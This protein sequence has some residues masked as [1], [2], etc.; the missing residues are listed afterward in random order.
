MAGDVATVAYIWRPQGPGRRAGGRFPNDYCYISRAFPRPDLLLG[1]SPVPYWEPVVHRIYH[2]DNPKLAAQR[3][4]LMSG[5]ATN[6]QYESVLPY[7]QFARM[8]AKIAHAYAIAEWGL[9]SFRGILPPY[10]LGQDPNIPYVVGGL[11]SWEG[12]LIITDGILHHTKFGIAV[13]NGF[14]HLIAAIQLFGTKY[15]RYC[16]VIG[17]PTIDLMLQFQ[18]P[19]HDRIFPQLHYAN[20]RALD[21]TFLTIASPHIRESWKLIPNIDV[22]PEHL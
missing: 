15:P 13:V 4:K 1:K 8:L 11:D 6:I 14:P 19:A 7:G 10:I 2:Y 16:V 3:A 9:N 22:P 21:K 5:G 17:T 20:S 12:P 18:P